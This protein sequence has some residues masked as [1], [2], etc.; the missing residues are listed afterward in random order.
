MPII[1]DLLVKILVRFVDSSIILSRR[2]QAIVMVAL[3][4][5]AENLKCFLDLFEFGQGLSIAR[6]LIRMVFQRQ[7]IACEPDGTNI[8]SRLNSKDLIVVLRGDSVGH[9]RRHC[10][11]GVG[12]FADSFKK[13]AR[14]VK[15]VLR[16]NQK[17]LQSK[18]RSVSDDREEVAETADEKAT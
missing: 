4:N 11:V 16:T 10:Y 8:S 2:T 3:G 12:T 17:P 15:R 1:P 7:T 13:G 9:L 18:K 6:V 5:I 14:M